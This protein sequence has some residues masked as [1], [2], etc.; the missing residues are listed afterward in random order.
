MD[1][2]TAS[3]VTTSSLTETAR[4]MP[5]IDWKPSWKE[6]YLVDF[7]RNSH[8]MICMVCHLRMHCIRSDTVTKHFNRVHRDIKSYSLTER[9][10]VQLAYMKHHNEIEK[11]RKKLRQY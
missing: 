8:E 10:K 4:K 3:V 9:R 7:D 11:S 1:S 5:R 6:R 2:S